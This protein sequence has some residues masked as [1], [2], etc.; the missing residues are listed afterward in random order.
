[1]TFQKQTLNLIVSIWSN[2]LR[3]AYRYTYMGV[4]ILY[5]YTGNNF[6]K[7]ILLF[8]MDAL[9]LKPYTRVQQSIYGKRNFSK[10]NSVYVYA[11]ALDGRVH[12]MY[13]LY[14]GIYIRTCGQL[15]RII[16]EIAGDATARRGRWTPPPLS[17]AL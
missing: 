3:F 5:Y 8:F 12:G 10:Y 17:R 7:S 15:F 2:V 1:M 6:C 16:G 14:Y 11:Y 9:Y 13:T 4:Y